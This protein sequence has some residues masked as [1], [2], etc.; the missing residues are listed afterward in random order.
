MFTDMLEASERMQEQEALYTKLS[1]K[2]IVSNAQKVLAHRKKFVKKSVRAKKRAKTAA[3]GFVRNITAMMISYKA[4]FKLLGS[5][6]G[7]ISLSCKGI[8]GNTTQILGITLLIGTALLGLVNYLK[9]LATAEGG[10]GGTSYGRYDENDSKGHIKNMI[11]EEAQAQKVDPALALAVADQESAFNPKAKSQ[12]GARGIFQMTSIACKQV[13]IPFDEKLYDPAHNIKYGIK[14][15]KWCLEH[16][17]TVEEALFAWNSGR[18]NLDK[19]KA[20]GDDLGTWNS[21]HRTSKEKGFTTQTLPKIGKYRSELS[22]LKPKK[23]RSSSSGDIRR[24]ANGGKIG[25]YTLQNP[26]RG[27]IDVSDRV[28]LYL[29]KTQGHG[30]ITSG[31]EGNHAQGILSHSSGNKIDVTPAVVSNESWANTAIPFLRNSETAFV[32]FEG[33]TKAEFTAIQNIIYA[34][35]DSTLRRICDG[36]ARQGGWGN[37][38]SKFLD[39]SPMNANAK[40]LDI[41]ICTNA[42]ESEIK[43][44][45]YNKLSNKGNS[46]ASTKTTS[47][48]Q[49]DSVSKNVPYTNEQTVVSSSTPKH[50]P[51][52]VSIS[53]PSKGNKQK[54]Q[55]VGTSNP[56]NIVANQHNQYVKA[57][58]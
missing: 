43:G 57:R 8:V 30:I 21:A 27:W 18:T 38:G 28:E 33:F 1:K 3:S 51:T 17:D 39:Y 58:K 50:S 11:I 46:N 22:S 49:N 6:L 55:D 20:R 2:S 7:S 36:P 37:R 45:Q 26:A 42:Y 44:A 24:Y 5:S 47:G 52:S 4:P 41:G 56:L 14:Y 54:G 15:L 12:T 10:F 53:S 40:H 31:A 19:A 34:K 23:I 29:R 13:G 48:G 9:G 35:I 25:G 32:V 16:T